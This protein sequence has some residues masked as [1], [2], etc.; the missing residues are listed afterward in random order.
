MFKYL[1]SAKGIR[2]GVVELEMS[3]YSVAEEMEVTVQIGDGRQQNDDSHQ[4]DK[5]DGETGDMMR[6]RSGCVASKDRKT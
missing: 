4:T 5:K 2:K 1:Q 3:E 6:L